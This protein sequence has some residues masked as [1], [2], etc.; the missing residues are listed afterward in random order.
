[1]KM[2][3]NYHA[4]HKALETKVVEAPQR[5]SDPKSKITKRVTLT[6]HTPL[7]SMSKKSLH[8]ECNNVLTKKKKR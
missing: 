7:G 4:E 8:D 5:Q 3:K 1:M 2:K 6:Y